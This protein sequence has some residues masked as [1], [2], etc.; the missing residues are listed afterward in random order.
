MRRAAG[1][2]RAGACARRVDKVPVDVGEGAD[3]VGVA[4][5]DRVEQQH[6][7]AFKH[8]HSKRP[9]LLASQFVT[10]RHRGVAS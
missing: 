6:F 3:R 1:R 7:E 5:L 4:V 10:D 9:Y 2:R 8:S